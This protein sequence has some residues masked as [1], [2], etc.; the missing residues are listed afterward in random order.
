MPR[1][2]S[3]K[4]IGIRK[5]QKHTNAY[6]APVFTSFVCTHI[7]NKQ[8]QLNVLQ[9]QFVLSSSSSK[10]AVA[11]PA[12]WQYPVLLRC[13]SVTSLRKYG[14]LNKYLRHLDSHQASPCTESHDPYA[15]H[16]LRTCWRAARRNRHHH[17]QAFFQGI[18]ANSL[19]LSGTG[20]QSLA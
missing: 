4:G 18:L 1:V 10:D 20:L 7:H 5:A 8:L 3:E 2:T 16:S 17:F 14:H 6:Y 9:A 12:I 11:I 13:F 15:K 19:A